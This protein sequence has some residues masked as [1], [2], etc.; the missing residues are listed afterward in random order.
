L[1][2]GDF[3]E[4]FGE[5]RTDGLIGAEAEQAFDTVEED[6]VFFFVELALGVEV[7][8][9]LLLFF[10]ALVGVFSEDNALAAEPGEGVE[11]AEG[12]GRV[13]FVAVLFEVA[14]EVSKGDL[15]EA[16]LER[17]VGGV[18]PEGV[19]VVTHALK[20]LLPIEG[21]EVL[22]VRAIVPVEYIIDSEGDAL[23]GH[24][25]DD[26]LIRFILVE[27]LVDQSA[28]FGRE[29]GDFGFGTAAAAR[30]ERCDGVRGMRVGC[31]GA[32]RHLGWRGRGRGGRGFV[33]GN[34]IEDI[35]CGHGGMMLK[36]NS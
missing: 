24:F 6:V 16:F 32:G 19:G 26:L 12:V 33:N 11:E 8:P 1:G 14:K 27:E 21:V 4:D 9:S 7:F 15:N 23:F 22:L 30:D 34:G 5:G 29:L 10:G 3:G 28:L 36:I 18:G 35:G 25:S 13:V 2:G 31:R 20:F 17:G